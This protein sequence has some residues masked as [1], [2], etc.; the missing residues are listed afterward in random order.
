MQ[1]IIRSI[2]VVI[3]VLLLGNGCTPA[4]LTGD[5]SGTASFGS[6]QNLTASF[7]QT[8]DQITGTVR[9]YGGYPYWEYNVACTVTGNTM[10]GYFYSDDIYITGDWEIEATISLDGSTITG[11]MEILGNGSTGTFELTRQ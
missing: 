11:I 1:Y 5:W 3:F 6:E 9:Y 4:N 10:T 7:T 2:F 8:G